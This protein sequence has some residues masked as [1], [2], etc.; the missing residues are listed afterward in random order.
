MAE[1]GP[2]DTTDDAAKPLLR[3]VRGNPTETELGALVLAVRMRM[4]E[5]ASDTPSTDTTQRPSNWAAYWRS[6]RQPVRTGLDAWR[7]SVHP[8]GNT[9]W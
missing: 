1:A 4:A 5:Q 8:A 6:V 9:G 7:A 2:R 3:V